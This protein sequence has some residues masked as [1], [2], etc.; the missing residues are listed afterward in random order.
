MS[1][2]I[3]GRSVPELAAE[4]TGPVAGATARQST[5]PPRRLVAVVIIATIVV[6]A[7]VLVPA[8]VFA[9]SSFTDVPPGHPFHDQITWTADAG[10][11]TGYQDGTFRP[12]DPVTRQAMAAF[13][14]RSY[15]LQNG[16]DL[17]GATSVTNSNPHTSP[18][19]GNVSGGLFDVDPIP[20]TIPAGTTGRI[21]VTASGTLRCTEPN[22]P[23]TSESCGVRVA[24]DDSPNFSGNLEQRVTAGNATTIPVA[25]TWVTE[26]MAPG[27]HSIRIQQNSSN[28][29]AG[30]DTTMMFPTLAITVRVHLL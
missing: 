17:F 28:N 29:D 8:T 30:N 12:N 24:M 4:S 23:V 5:R 22:D 1:H 9:V 3:E 21:E 10:I 20:V 19:W 15:N 25:F 2:I 6:S 18:I 11:S 14:Q 16:A 13:M 27:T 26:A 7:L